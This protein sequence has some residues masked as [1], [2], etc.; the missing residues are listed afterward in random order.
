MGRVPAARLLDRAEPMGEAKYVAFEM[1][2]ECLERD[3]FRLAHR[4]GPVE[5]PGRGNPTHGITIDQPST[6]RI[7]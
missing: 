6:Q 4:L 7:R 1:F 5:Q 3:V 2:Y